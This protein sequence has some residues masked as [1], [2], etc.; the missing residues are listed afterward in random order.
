M[1]SVFKALSDPSRRKILDLLKQK[2]MAVGEL[3]EH[4]AMAQPSL[5]HHLDTLK[6][7][8]LVVPRREGQNIYYSINLSVFEEAEE[9][10]LKLFAR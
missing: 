8:G 4:F 5:S 6:R 3:L 9:F 1:D 10:I 7:A 2:E